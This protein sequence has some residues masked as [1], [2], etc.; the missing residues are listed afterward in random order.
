MEFGVGTVVPIP[1]LVGQA[2]VP[3]LNLFK[4]GLALVEQ[5]PLNGFSAVKYRDLT[6]SHG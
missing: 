2:F 5:L 6:S 1:D 4:L 3:I